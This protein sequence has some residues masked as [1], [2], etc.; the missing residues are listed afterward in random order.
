M[1]M[2]PELAL[3]LLCL[4]IFCCRILDVSFSTLRIIL[5][6]RGK[7]LQA[8]F[9]G[10]CEVFIWFLIVREALNSAG[11]G[12]V[13]ALAYACGFAA[14][15]YIGGH[16]ANRFIIGDI[17][18][19]AIT[20]CRDNEVLSDIRQAGYALSVI[21]V[22]SSEF[23]EEKYLLIAEIKTN[24]LDAYKKLLKSLDPGAFI[25]VNETKNVVGGY[26][27]KKR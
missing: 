10:F 25:M 26:F 13:L 8:T 7:T 18:V 23:G 24:Q 1:E 11:G 22:N 15:T 12:V 5:S 19:H 3:A 20:S 16:L 9:M 2:T 6:V 27:E 21:N 17:A 14:G 4:K